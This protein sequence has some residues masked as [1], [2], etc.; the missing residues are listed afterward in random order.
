MVN[1]PECGLVV[2]VHRGVESGLYEP[3]RPE[4]HPLGHRAD[5]FQRRQ[6]SKG[7]ARTHPQYAQASEKLAIAC[8]RTFIFA[9]LAPALTFTEAFFM[10]SGTWQIAGRRTR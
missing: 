4:R 1:K 10:P 3:F 9:P 6:G 7:R 8:V 2:T 5:L